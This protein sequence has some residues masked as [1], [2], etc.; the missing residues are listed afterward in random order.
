MES[1]KNYSIETI[2]AV[3]YK[4]AYWLIDNSVI[5]VSDEIRDRIRS[6]YKFKR[7]CIKDR[8]ELRNKEYSDLELDTYIG[9]NGQ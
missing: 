8:D 6:T 2:L 3:D 4:Y 7:Q 5:K 1:I 9:I